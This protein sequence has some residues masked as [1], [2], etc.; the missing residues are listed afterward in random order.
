MQDRL[1]TIQVIKQTTPK[2][3]KQLG[4]GRERISSFSSPWKWKVFWSTVIVKVLSSSSSIPITAPCE[5]KSKI[6]IRQTMTSAIFTIA[7][8][9]ECSMHQW[10]CKQARHRRKRSETSFAHGGKPAG[11]RGQGTI[12]P[13]KGTFTA[14][15]RTWIWGRG[16]GS[17]T[18]AESGIRVMSQSLSPSA[19]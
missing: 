18:E 7:T 14:C 16:R 17:N 11:R 15:L 3:K 2:R 13:C 10:H 5:T 12:V 8:A 6:P 19:C 1:Q 9:L 4:P